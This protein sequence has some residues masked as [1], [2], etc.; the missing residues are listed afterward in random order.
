M[1]IEKHFL[2]HIWP[3]NRENQQLR[4]ATKKNQPA[5]KKLAPSVVIDLNSKYYVQNSISKLKENEFLNYTFKLIPS[6]TITHA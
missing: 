3:E 6:E 2:T 1:N 4:Q 5:A